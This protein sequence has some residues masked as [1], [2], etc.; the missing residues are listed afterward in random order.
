MDDLSLVLKS[1]EWG[2]SYEQMES[3]PSVRN[4][5]FDQREMLALE[6]QTPVRSYHHLFHLLKMCYL[7]REEVAIIKTDKKRGKSKS[8]FSELQ[9]S[10][11]CQFYGPVST[12]RQGGGLANTRRSWLGFGTLRASFWPQLIVTLQKRE[13]K[14]TNGW[15]W[16]TEDRP[17]Y[18]GKT[19]ML[20]QRVTASRRKEGSEK[21]PKFLY[22]G[23]HLRQS[24]RRCS[25]L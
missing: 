11:S 5:I 17:E 7:S 13:L 4:N 12:Q 15:F 24:C 6:A 8:M 9:W 19:T 20:G 16:L 1:S 21:A 14:K 10:R 25:P 22:K 2:T 3:T 18:G 23:L